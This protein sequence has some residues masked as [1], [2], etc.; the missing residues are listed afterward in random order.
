[1]QSLKSLPAKHQSVLSPPQDH[2]V[3]DKQLSKTRSK[4][5]PRIGPSPD[6]FLND[7]GIRFGTPKAITS[8]WFELLEGFFFRTSRG[9][10]PRAP[11]AASQTGPEA[12]LAAFWYP[13]GAP[14]GALTSWTRTIE[15]N[16]KS[17]RK[18]SKC[19]EASDPGGT[20]ETPR[21]HENG[22]PAVVAPHGALGSAG[23]PLATACQIFPCEDLPAPSPD[24]CPPLFQLSRP[25][26]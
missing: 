24:P 9:R 8:H 26:L 15:I 18:H 17:K 10:P 7:F 11:L 23:H 5:G 12:L 25:P 21:S 22:W 3:S 20:R 2:Q 16:E 1:M 13:L 6:R 14:W 19:H 4:T